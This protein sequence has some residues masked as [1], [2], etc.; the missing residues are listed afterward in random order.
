M[1]YEALKG[2]T[3]TNA[4][5]GRKELHK[6]IDGLEVSEDVKSE[7]KKITP[8]NYTGTDPGF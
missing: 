4:A 5:I 2:L 7:L 8:H 1:P 3:R 6:F